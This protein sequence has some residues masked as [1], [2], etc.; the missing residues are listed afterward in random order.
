MP[1]SS[2]NAIAASASSRELGRRREIELEHRRAVI[3]RLAEVAVQPGL[4][5]KLAYCTQ[6][7]WSRPNC[8]R[9]A[10]MSASL[11]PGSTSSAV[12][13]PV[14]RTNRKIVRDSSNSETSE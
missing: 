4:S 11:A 12:G 5:M 14:T 7:G 2:E 8:S 10:A 3:E 13:S 1:I 9:M 6:I